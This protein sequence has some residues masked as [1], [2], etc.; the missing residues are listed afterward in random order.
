MQQEFFSMRQIT[1]DIQSILL[2]LTSLPEV[3]QNKGKISVRLLLVI[4]GFS[5]YNNNGKGV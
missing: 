3:E 1:K 5:P 2:A 4:S